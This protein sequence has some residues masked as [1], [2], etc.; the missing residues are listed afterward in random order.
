[1]Y[2][3]VFVVRLLGFL[4]LSFLFVD[5]STLKQ[6][7]WGVWGER[8]AQTVS[9]A[10]DAFR[11]IAS[12]GGRRFPSKGSSARLE[13]RIIS[14]YIR[15]YYSISYHVIC[16]RIIMYYIMLVYCCIARYI[17]EYYII[18]HHIIVCYI[19]LNKYNITLRPVHLLRVSMSEGLTQANT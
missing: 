7:V 11:Q 5:I 10:C 9:F 1:M 8:Q 17:I 12:T 6:G 2:V 19:V 16:Y 13:L 14:C 3:D 15:L 4:T 18:L